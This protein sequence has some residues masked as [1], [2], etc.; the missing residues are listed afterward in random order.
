[1]SLAGITALLSAFLEPDHDPADRAGHLPARRRTRY[2][3]GAAPDHRGDRLQ[4]RRHR[5][6]DRRPPNIIIAGA[7]G[8]SFNDFTL[9]MAPIVALTFAVVMPLLY[10][11]FRRRLA[12]EEKNR[13]AV[14]GLNAAAYRLG[15]AV[16][17]IQ[18]TDPPPSSGVLVSSFEASRTKARTSYP[19]ARAP[20]TTWRPAPPVAPNTARSWVVGHSWLS[21]AMAAAVGGVRSREMKPCAPA[22]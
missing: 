1:M 13:K 22:G 12:V 15:D 16:D 6:P 17:F 4:H 8:L 5:H 2:R 18:L 14:M 10:F 3:G 9:N 19:A 21:I 20:A 11:V 7:T